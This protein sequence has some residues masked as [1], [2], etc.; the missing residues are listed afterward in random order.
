MEEKYHHFFKLFFYVRFKFNA[1]LNSF[2]WDKYITI[3][4]DDNRSAQLKINEIKQDKTL[5]F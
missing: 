4:Y 1:N 5:W 3:T 2:Y